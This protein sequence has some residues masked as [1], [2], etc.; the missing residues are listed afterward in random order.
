[1]AAEATAACGGDPNF[2]VVCS[3]MQKY[4]D[5]LGIPELTFL[6]LEKYLTDTR[7]GG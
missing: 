3:F 1:M 6:T 2:A 5:L 4:G 7:A